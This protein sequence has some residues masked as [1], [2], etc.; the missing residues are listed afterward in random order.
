M[1]SAGTAGP[2]GLCCRHNRALCS[3]SRRDQGAGAD[4]DRTSPARGERGLRGSTR[5]PNV[6]RQVLVVTVG[7]GAEGIPHPDDVGESSRDKAESARLTASGR[8]LRPVRTRFARGGGLVSPTGPPSDRGRINGEDPGSFS[9]SRRSCNPRRPAGKAPRDPCH[10]RSFIR[11][12]HACSEGLDDRYGH[13]PAHVHHPAVSFGAIVAW[14]CVV[15]AITSLVAASA[16]WTSTARSS[17]GSSNE[18]QLI[19]SSG[20]R[21]GRL[22]VVQIT[23]FRVERRPDGSGQGDRGLRARRPGRLL[24]RLAS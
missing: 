4:E 6:V 16:C 17:G 12:N 5:A 7:S 14:S 18:T 1:W 3:L 10:Q 22:I 8:D 21:G 24:I 23:R 2:R 9:S 20:C 13:D 15:L 11:R 19:G